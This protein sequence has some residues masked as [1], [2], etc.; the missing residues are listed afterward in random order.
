MERA[1][2]A[3]FVDLNNLERGVQE[4]ILEARRHV[5]ELFANCQ[6]NVT[7]M[8]SNEHYDIA[9]LETLLDPSLDPAFRGLLPE[10]TG[11]TTRGKR[12]LRVVTQ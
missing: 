11:P 1:L 6:P 2:Q 12:P 10:G 5:I 3:I 9:P 7:M 8:G 4:R